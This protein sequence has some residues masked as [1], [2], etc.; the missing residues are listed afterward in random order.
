MIFTII[1]GSFNMHLKRFPNWLNIL[2]GIISI[3]QISLQ[4]AFIYDLKHKVFL[5]KP[6]T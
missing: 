6:V 3:I 2:N 1:T 5:N 4:I